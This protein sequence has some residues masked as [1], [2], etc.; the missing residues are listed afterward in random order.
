MRPASCR[1]PFLVIA[2]L[3]ASPL[4]AA[5]PQSGCALSLVSRDAA[6]NVPPVASA[7]TP[8]LTP[9]ARFVAFESDIPLIPSDPPAG[10]QIYRLDRRSGELI[11]VTRSIFGSGPPFGL[12]V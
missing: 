9:E 4:A 7:V 10:R 5:A 1:A 11:R 8:A 2:A 6:G 12:N 3:V